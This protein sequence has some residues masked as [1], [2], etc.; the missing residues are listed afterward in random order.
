MGWV[1]GIVFGLASI[2][3][4]DGE[5]SAVSVKA[6]AIDHVVT[7]VVVRVNVIVVGHQPVLVIANEQVGIVHAEEAASYALTGAKASAYSI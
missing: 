1:S 5:V 2:A 7:F 3:R 4:L 6:G